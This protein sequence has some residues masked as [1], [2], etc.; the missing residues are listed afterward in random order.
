MAQR[1][2]TDEDLERMEIEN[3][4][5]LLEILDVLREV[6]TPFETSESDED[7]EP[8]VTHDGD[9]NVA[10]R[11]L[12]VT[13]T[14]TL[15]CSYMDLYSDPAYQRRARLKLHNAKD[16]FRC[17]TRQDVIRVMDSQYYRDT[18]VYLNGM[19]PENGGREDLY[20]LVAMYMIDLEENGIYLDMDA[21][22]NGNDD[23]DDDNNDDD[24]DDNDK[25]KNKENIFKKSPPP[26]K[27]LVTSCPAL[28]K[29]SIYDKY[30]FCRGRLVQW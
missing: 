8:P 29:K 11:F 12:S 27:N 21:D 26:K 5:K 3:D 22:D 28:S 4:L 16:S 13:V 1:N 7:D 9:W 25:D 2:V 17:Q 6:D 20:P 30:F 10:T 19:Y 23:N 15:Q 24:K 14:P 18:L